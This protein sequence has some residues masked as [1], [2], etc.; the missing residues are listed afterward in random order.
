MAGIRGKPR[1]NGKYQGWYVDSNGKRKFFIGTRNRAETLRIAQKIEDDHRQVRLGYRP[2]S[3]PADKYKSR[4]FAEV[5]AEYISWGESQGGRGGRPWATEH[6]R[7]RRDNLQ[8]WQNQLGIQTLGEVN[9]ILPRVEKAL[10]ELQNLG[11]SGKTLQNYQEAI[12]AFCDWAVQRGYLTNDPL[13]SAKYYDITPRARRRILTREEIQVLLE[14]VPPS[15]RLLYQV[16]MCTGLRAKELRSLK[17]CDL[18]PDMLALNLHAEWT[19][20]RKP[21]MQPIPQW[22]LEELLQE[23]KGKD[24]DA[25][26]WKSIKT[27]QRAWTRSGSCAYSKMDSSR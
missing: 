12:C 13:R 27:P 10:R 26:Y 8:W 9:G 21:G 15:R 3:S 20:N 4:P 6:A 22:L 14:V 1:S 23:S 5:V 2:P 11:R 24:L 18:N 19:K 25:P 7:K 16:A 17:V